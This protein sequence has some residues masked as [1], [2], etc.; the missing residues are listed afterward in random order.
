M[1]TYE[2]HISA[3]LEYFGTPAMREEWKAIL[4]RGDRGEEARF[5]ARLQDRKLNEREN[6]GK[7][8]GESYVAA[9]GRH[10]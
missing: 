6:N 7:A 9:D 4:A 10:D 2:Q 5:L 3:R 8:H 1:N